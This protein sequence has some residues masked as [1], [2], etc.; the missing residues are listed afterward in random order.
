MVSRA[1][2]THTPNRVIRVEDEDW[3]EF[4]DAV[5]VRQR[6]EAIRN[7]IRWYLHRPGA[8]APKR[9]ARES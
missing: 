7:F 1:K 2:D 5:G 4:G 9:P 8:H 3:E 6:A